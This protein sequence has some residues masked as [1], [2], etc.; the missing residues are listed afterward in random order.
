MAIPKLYVVATPIGNLQDMTLRALETLRANDVFFAEDSRELRK[1][2]AAHGISVQGKVIHSYAQ[3]NMK[4]AT[5]RALEYLRAGSHVCLVSDRGTPCI[6]DP[7]AQ[8]VGRAIEDGF[9]VIP[10][11]GPS[12]LVAV[13]S[14][15]GLEFTSFIFFGFFPHETKEREKIFK[16]INETN[17][18]VVFFESPNRIRKTLQT[19]SAAFLQGQVFLAREVTK[20]FE[21]FQR[22]ALNALVLDEIKEK[23]E[24]VIVL[25]PG[26]QASQSVGWEQALTLRLCSDK[27]WAKTISSCHD[28]SAKTVYDALQRAKAART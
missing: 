17:L 13:L 12:S 27:E 4:E 9:S 26:P 22:F 28:V 18:P 21:S 1:L 14:V 23:G 5:A 2:M 3:H 10:V 25:D 19:L 15:C 11:P 20:M 6:S 8:L 24:Y 7:G 16:Q